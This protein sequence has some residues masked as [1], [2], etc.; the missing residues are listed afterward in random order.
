MSRSAAVQLGV[1][2]ALIAQTPRTL[3]KPLLTSGPD[4]WI[5][6]HSGFYYYIN[7][8]G[9]GLV[10]RKT[11]SLAD[12]ANAERREVWRAVP[13]TAYARDIW[14]PELHFIRGKWYIYFAADSGTNASHRIWVLENASSDPLTGDWQ[15]K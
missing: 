12:L 14:A 9:S 2:G 13:G 3:V 6:W 5:T 8:T 15:F 10:I 11:R 7:T 4:P 1:C